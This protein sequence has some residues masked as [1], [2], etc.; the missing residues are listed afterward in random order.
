M[1]GSERLFLNVSNSITDRRWTDRLNDAG[2]RTAMAMAQRHAIPEILA[3]I[4]AARGVE[5]DETE[6]FLAPTIREL[7]PDPSVLVGMEQAVERLAGA[8]LSGEKVALFGDYDV[9]GA[10]SSA[11]MVRFLG[12]CGLEPLVHIP[13][14]IVEGYGPNIPAIDALIDAG[15]TL[16]VTLDCGTTSVAALTHAVERGID[17][18]V[19]DHHLAHGDLPP[20]LAVVNPNRADDLSGLGHLC[21]AGVTFMVLAGLARHLRKTGAS[22]PDLMAMVDLVA[23]A[24]ICDVVPLK[25]LNRAFVRRGIEIMHRGDNAGIVALAM[26]ARISGPVSAYH[27]G[28]LIGPRI[29]AGGRIG[30]ASA[31]AKLLATAHEHEAFEIAQRLNELNAERQTIE[32]RAVEEAVAVADAEI[33]DGEG[34]AVLVVASPDWHPGVVGLVAARLRERFGRPAFAVAQNSAGGGTGSGRSIPGVDLG[35]AVLAAVDDGTIEKG[36]GHAMAAGISLNPDQ[37]GPFRA[38]MQTALGAQVAEKMKLRSIAIDA[39]LTARSL[40]IDLLTEMERAGPFGAG[41]STPVLALPAHTVSYAKVVGKGGHVSA[42]LRAGDGASIR[43]IAFGAADTPLGHALL[44][45]PGG[46]PLHVCG[47]ASINVWQGRS[48]AQFRVLDVAKPQP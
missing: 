20:A 5:L 2:S 3:R 16:L 25:G 38:A 30:D 36:G 32:R 15:A 31:G 45:A 17:V 39:A 1:D 6:A 10:C 9:D 35:A 33:G 8:I 43:A 23:L 14:R 19:I 46:P 26:A 24:T 41:N 7:M 28:Y 13:D 22:P 48:E 37:L 18:V 40:N 4:L 29:N 11:L 21:A 27:L 12:G 34:P 47:T 42:T 44:E